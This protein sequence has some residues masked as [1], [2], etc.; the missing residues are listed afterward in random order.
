MVNSIWSL[1]ALDHHVIG[2]DEI[3]EDAIFSKRFR[4][5]N[6]CLF[7]DLCPK[8]TEVFYLTVLLF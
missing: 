8:E 5:L 1:K 3:I 7:V 6:P 4:A 2:D